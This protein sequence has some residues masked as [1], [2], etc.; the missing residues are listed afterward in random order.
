MSGTEV[1]DTISRPWFSDRCHEE[2]ILSAP[3]IEG[4][5]EDTGS[6]IYFDRI[7]KGEPLS[8]IHSRV[9]ITTDSDANTSTRAQHNG[10]I[11]ALN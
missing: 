3:I 2:M 4:P 7:G 5:F 6:Q 8:R 9:S 10:G 1:W 11:P